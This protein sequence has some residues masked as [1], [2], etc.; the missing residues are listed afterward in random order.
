MQ[1]RE[2]SN[3]SFQTLLLR[4]VLVFYHLRLVPVAALFYRNLSLKILFTLAYVLRFLP[5]SVLVLR[6][7][8]T[9]LWID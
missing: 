1:S 6:H 8:H 7:A 2:E 3:Q 5:S 9:G 4:I